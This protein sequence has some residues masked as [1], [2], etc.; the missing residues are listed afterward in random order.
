MR[1]FKNGLDT[2]SKNENTTAAAPEE[3]IK[4]YSGMNEE[5]LMR[6]LTGLTQSRKAEGTYDPAAIKRG[7]EAISPLLSGEQR[8]KLKRVIEAL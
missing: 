3:L 2:R 8:A 4:R 5:A 1:S 7:V 6:E